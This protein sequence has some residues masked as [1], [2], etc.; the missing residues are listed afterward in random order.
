MKTQFIQ[1]LICFY[2]SPNKISLH[3][4]IFNVNDGEQVNNYKKFTF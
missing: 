4:L 1:L 2:P 3:N